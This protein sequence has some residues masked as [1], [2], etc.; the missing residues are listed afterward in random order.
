VTARRVLGNIVADNQY[1]TTD[2][3][4]DSPEVVCTNRHGKIKLHMRNPELHLVKAETSHAELSVEVP[5]G[6]SLRVEADADH[7]DILSDLP[8][9]VPGTGGNPADTAG[10]AGP[11]V[12]LRN[13]FG[14]IFV[15]QRAPSLDA[16]L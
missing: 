12:S 3:D 15:R 13:H 5:Q 10:F 7:G 11:R 14:N 6:I 1:G 4:V 2:L 9:F 16:G 8:V